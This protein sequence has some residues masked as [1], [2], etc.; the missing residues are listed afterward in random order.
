MRFRHHKRTLWVQHEN[1]PLIDAGYYSWSAL[2]IVQVEG[3]QF[4]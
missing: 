3:A 2:E 4:G 1:W